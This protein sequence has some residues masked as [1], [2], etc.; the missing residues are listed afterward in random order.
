MKRAAVSVSIR[1]SIHPFQFDDAARSNNA[2]LAT[3]KVAARL[4]ELATSRPHD[5]IDVF[6]QGYAAATR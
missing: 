3:C 4:L 1:V 2:M 6:G 5:G